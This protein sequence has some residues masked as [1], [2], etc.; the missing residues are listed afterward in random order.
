MGIFGCTQIPTSSSCSYE[1]KKDYLNLFFS[2]LGYFAQWPFD[3][4]GPK[5]FDPPGTFLVKKGVM[6]VSSE[7]SAAKFFLR[8]SE[9]NLSQLLYF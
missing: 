2:G 5:K 6:G 8:N 3:K 9:Q 4:T 1:N 7:T